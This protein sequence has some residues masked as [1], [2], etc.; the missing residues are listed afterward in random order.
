[1]KNYTPNGLCIDQLKK[2]AKKIK[3]ENNLK[4][5]A[6]LD[7]IAKTR[8]SFYNWKSLI[9]NSSYSNT[10]SVFSLKSL[11][12]TYDKFSVY[13]NRPMITNYTNPGYAANY[14]LKKTISNLKYKGKILYVT[15]YKN[16]DLNLFFKNINHEAIVFFNDNKSSNEIL[17]LNGLKLVKSTLN[18]YGFLILNDFYSL[19]NQEIN[20]I[21]E[22]IIKMCSNLGI[23][24]YFM[25]N[26]K[27]NY[28]FDIV[29]KYSSVMVFPFDKLSVNKELIQYVKESEKMSNVLK[30]GLIDFKV[31]NYIS[32][33]KINISIKYEL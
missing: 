8:T 17:I 22:E 14:I 24:I 6:A 7:Y 2:D 1:M 29:D 5:T 21:L 9:K 15:S 28:V 10:I 20:L 18:N 25:T 13:K 26:I 32:K 33:E 11:D 27:D 4:M 19:N 31:Y 16:E 30:D 3:K 23:P 12:N